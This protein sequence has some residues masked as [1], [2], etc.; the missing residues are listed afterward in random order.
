[1]GED[2][3][4]KNDTAL[5]MDAVEAMDETLSAANYMVQIASTK[6]EDCNQMDTLV[7]KDFDIPVIRRKEDQLN[8]FLA[9]NKHFDT[10]EYMSSGSN[11]NENKADNVDTAN[12]ISASTQCESYD[13]IR[14]KEDQL[15]VFLASPMHNEETFTKSSEIVGNQESK[16]Q[17][18]YMGDMFKNS[19]VLSSNLLDKEK[20]QEKEK[21]IEDDM[22]EKE[23]IKI[24]ESNN[25]DKENIEIIKHKKSENERVELH[26]LEKENRAKEKLEEENIE[27]KKKEK[28]RIKANTVNEQ[29]KADLE[30]AR[31]EEETLSEEKREKE[32]IDL[33]K[34][35]KQR[36]EKENIEREIIELENMEKHS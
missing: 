9:P 34:K 18:K 30:R 19:L 21:K 15:N 4:F 2:K 8:V 23:E 17:G 35:E 22:I 10:L 32:K 27:H 3:Y 13:F 20:L 24:L 16:Y 36:I 25:G 28:T 26:R 31:M 7:D 33:E 5:E 6:D 12:E 14:S 1:M 29:E 11:D